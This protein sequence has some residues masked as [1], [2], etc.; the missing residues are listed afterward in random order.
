[1]T[2]PTL[3]AGSVAATAVSAAVRAASAVAAGFCLTAGL[4]LIAWALTPSGSESAAGAVHVAGVAFASAHFLP[5]SLQG[6]ALTIRP[7]LLTGVML[8]VIVTAAGR[9]RPVHGRLLEA[10]H[11]CI[12]ALAYGLAVDILAALAAPSTDVTPGLGAP[13]LLA[14]LGA[15]GSLAGSASAWR[16]WWADTAPVWMRA[17]LGGAGAT[18]VA[19][20]A[21]ASA[22]L[23][24]RLVVTVPDALHVAGLT[25][26]SLGDTI[27]LALLCLALVPNAVIAAIGYVSGAGF[28][29]GAA[30]YSPLAVHTAPLP[31]IPLLSAV[32]GATPGAAAWATLAC[33]VI[34]AVVGGVILRRALAGS[35]LEVW[36][37][38]AVCAAASVAV[39]IAVVAASAAAGGG[40]A[41]GP[42]A[43]TGAPPFA[44]GG[45]IALVT[46]VVG[47]AV[48]VPAGR[49]VRSAA[50]LGDTV[51]LARDLAVA[52]E[53]ADDGTADDD[54]VDFGDIAVDDDAASV[55]SGTAGT[56]GTA[57]DSTIDDAGEAG[58]APHDHDDET[59][60]LDP[61][62][63]DSDT[64]DPDSEDAGAEND[65]AA[66][67]PAE[68]RPA[69]SGERAD[70]EPPSPVDTALDP[71]A[72]DTAPDDPFRADPAASREPAIVGD[73][74]A[75]AADGSGL[76]QAG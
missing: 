17:A 46:L 53:T 40:V 76:A 35:R 29:L 37:R 73:D 69:A 48:A 24:V 45:L 12:F 19:L 32:P 7:L 75:G 33:P 51:D 16:S 56:A 30:G 68:L 27:T 55:I 42:W 70:A 39:G 36:R 67:M 41:G 47:G 2:K 54:A 22:V 62:F 71:V 23:A 6:T 10:L 43:V 72:R 63:E 61:A 52:D 4:S 14:A 9:G 74:D 50:V 60:D 58:I 57:D 3:H 20:S 1:M 49:A 34:A 8:A 44:T 38:L 26:R 65:D 18:L 64:D 31:A 13:L 5:V 28:T 11:A 21:A 25:A 15:V 66:A 59:D